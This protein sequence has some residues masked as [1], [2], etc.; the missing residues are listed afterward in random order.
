MTT[1]GYRV[2]IILILVCGWLIEADA[3]RCQSAGKRA[4]RGATP[5]TK[6]ATLAVEPP[7]PMVVEPPP[8]PIVE[9]PP[10]EPIVE[11]PPPPVVEPPPPVVIEPPPDPAPDPEPVS[12]PPPED[13]FTFLT[14]DYTPGEV[15][16]AT[17]EHQPVTPYD[18]H[19]ETTAQIAPVEDYQAVLAYR[20][21]GLTFDGPL[22]ATGY[23]G[24]IG[25]LLRPVMADVVELDGPY[26]L[27]TFQAY[28]W[29]T[30]PPV[31][32]ILAT[33]TVYPY[34]HADPPGPL[35]PVL[36]DLA[37]VRF[38]GIRLV[39]QAQLPESRLCWAAVDVPLT[40]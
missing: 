13:R 33:F 18:L 24:C 21:E 7:P 9:P 1:R 12:T 27:E 6:C 17:L 26:D 22:V 2:G 19:L 5:A 31:A 3:E 8:A 37:G 34:D 30:P 11:P 16:T 38:L 40:P 20:P 23:G 32:R 14:L 25:D 35:A 29:Q 15:D 39:S 4:S 36:L 28:R 10:P